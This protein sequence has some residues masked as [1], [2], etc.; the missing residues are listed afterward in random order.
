MAVKV[1]AVICTH[2]GGTRFR[3]DKV[4]ELDNTVMIRKGMSIPAQPL[5]VSYQYVCIGCN[6]VL[7]EEFTHGHVTVR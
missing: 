2:C 1:E 4:M 5:H 6:N 7:D 3:E